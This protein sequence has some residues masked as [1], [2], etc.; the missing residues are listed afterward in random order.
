MQAFFRW[1]FRCNFSQKALTPGAIAPTTVAGRVRNLARANVHELLSEARSPETA[2]DEMLATYSAALTEARNAVQEAITSLRVTEGKQA[3]DEEEVATWHHRAELATARATT[4][5][6]RD[7]AKAAASERMALEA[8]KHERT[9]K[10]RV[11][12]RE[13]GLM[14]QRD[15]LDHL[16]RDMAKMEKRYEELQEKRDALVNRARFAAA[17][18]TI[19]GAVGSDAATAS[20]GK[21]TELERTVLE[22]EALAQ[23]RR[24][25]AASSTEEQFRLLEEEMRTESASAALTSMAAPTKKVLA[26]GEGSN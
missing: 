19:A 22:R 10:L 14:H 18:E 16:K 5:Q 15:A 9:L 6:G 3:A 26:S 8:L 21:L 20:A 17:Q 25:L 2:A 4:L 13:P 1:F 11:Q 12:G 24:E 23:G 7:P